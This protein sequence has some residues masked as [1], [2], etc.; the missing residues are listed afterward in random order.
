VTQIGAN[1][2]DAGNGSYGICHVIDASRSLDRLDHLMN[3]DSLNVDDREY[4]FTIVDY[5]KWTS[6]G[7]RGLV[8]EVQSF[9]E[10]HRALIIQFPMEF[11]HRHS[12]PHRQRPKVDLKDLGQA[13]QAA[14]EGGWKPESRGKPFYYLFKRDSAASS[15]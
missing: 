3:S 13:I 9:I 8:V 6:D 15:S 5:P 7:W 4:R 2:T 14:L 10:A 11:S 12:T 1:K